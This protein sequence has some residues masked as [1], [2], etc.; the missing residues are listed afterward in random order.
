MGT[1]E[2][3]LRATYF[4]HVRKVGK[5]PPGTASRK[6]LRVFMPPR[7]GPPVFSTKEPPRGCVSPSGAGKGQ[8]TAP[9]AARCRS[10]LLD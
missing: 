9:R 5:A 10:V 2:F 8:D 4:A 7:P 3:R 6:T 1:L